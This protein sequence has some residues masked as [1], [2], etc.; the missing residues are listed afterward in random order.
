[1]K[2]VRPSSS[3]SLLGSLLSLNNLRITLS[4]ILTVIF[5]SACFQNVVTTSISSTSTSTSAS[6]VIPYPLS[7]PGINGVTGSAITLTSLSNSSGGPGVTLYL[8][9]TNFLPG[10]TVTIGGISCPAQVKSTFVIT[11]TVPANAAGSP[12]AYD[13]TVTNPDLTSATLTAAFTYNLSP[14]ITSIVPPVGGSGTSVTITGTNFISTSCPSG[15]SCPSVTIGGSAC[16][17]T[18]GSSTSVTCTTTAHIPGQAS[19]VFTNAD[20]QQVILYNGYTYTF[21]SNQVASG[22]DHSCAIVNGGVACWGNNQYGQLGNSNYFNTSSATSTPT[23]VTGITSGV[24]AIATGFYHT[25]A[26]INGG[27]QCWGNNNFGQL[28]N[29][30]TITSSP[31]GTA[32]PVTVYSSGTTAL[33]NVQAIT[34]GLYHTC[35]LINS[36]VQCWG[37]NNDGQLGNNSTVDS[38]YPV[39]VT[40]GSGNFLTGIQAISAGENFTCALGQSGN[41]FCWGDDSSEQLGDYDGT[42]AAK[43]HYV[44]VKVSSGG[45]AL[46][47]VQAIAAGG[48]HTCAIQSGAVL[49][50]GNDTAGQLGTGASALPG[51]N[52]TPAAVQF[53]G[54]NLTNVQSIS[55]GEFHTCAISNAATYCWGD[56][57]GGKLGNGNTTQQDQAVATLF[58]GLSTGAVAVT[59]GGRHSCQIMSSGIQCWGLNLY[60][61]LGNQTNSGAAT[62]NSTPLSV[63]GTVSATPTSGFALNRAITAMGTGNAHACA[64]VNGNVLCWG[65]NGSGQVGDG[66]QTDR[67]VPTAV[68]NFGTGYNAIAVAGGMSHTCALLGTSVTVSGHTS[69]VVCWGDNT[70][71]QLGDGTNTSQLSP[72]T[73]VQLT[74][75]AQSIAVGEF[76]SCAI[77]SGAVECWGWNFAGQVGTATTSTT[78]TTPV[79]VTIS[80]ASGI[81]AIAAG[82]FHTCA[83]DSGSGKV[84]CWGSNSSG[85]LGGTIASGAN[86]TS[87]PQ[88][89]GIVNAL[90][91]SSSFATSMITAGAFHTCA[92]VTGNGTS[93]TVQGGSWLEC[94][95]DNSFGQLG[96]CSTAN[97]GIGVVATT[98]TSSCSS[99]TFLA[100]VTQIS[101]GYN[102]TCA[103]VN[104]ILNCWGYN[105]EGQL[106][107]NTTTNSTFPT[108]MLNSAG[109]G[110]MTGIQSVAGGGYFTCALIN[111][112]IQCAGANANGELGNNSLT[113]SLLPVTA[114]G[115]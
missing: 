102:H 103:I 74:G 48:F 44:P 12:P 28:G 91:G 9:G 43:D 86:F 5:Q 1:L 56:N 62:A 20:G 38:D 18:A 16:T 14:T 17:V 110:S 50:W 64:I 37:H 104:G 40:D 45:A 67:A 7:G 83:V 25:C 27:I 26:L 84:Y 29:G 100:G 107:L 112:M 13:V 72:A 52:P 93:S 22:Y 96:N 4:L 88:T 69:N 24:Q 95:G 99:S 49:C 78:L 66:T 47:G 76:H 73:V 54:G 114:A 92:M 85:Q 68:K 39:Q 36:G 101:A 31:F 35:A 94:W 105:L 61:E 70:Y 23:F 41:V 90:T 21:V 71:G 87:T 42:F 8:N 6:T 65:M 98:L 19:V 59:A 57:S 97:P 33:S 2:S 111:G 63:T 77:V 46:S 115:F 79:A 30:A 89:A 53:G 82:A 75:L 80:G 109:T 3:S 108:P 51:P 55:A 11:C 81:E 106:G 60:G 113:N 58:S 10:A 34:A 15:S 32:T